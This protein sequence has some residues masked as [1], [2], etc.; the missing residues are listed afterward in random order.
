VGSAN[1]IQIAWVRET[2]P[3]TTP[4]SPRMR[5]VRATGESLDYTPDFVDSD[6]L[7][8]DRMQGAPI[9]VMQD[10]KGGLNS[11]L[12]F[13][14]DNSPASDIWRS[15]FWSTWVNTNSRDNDGVAD[16][17]IT[18]VATAG[19][20]VTCTTGTSFAANELVRFTGFG[21]T[22]NN[23]IFKCTTASATVPAFAGSG[24]TDEA[25]PPAAARMQVV[26]FI[27]AAGDINATASGISSTALN[28][29]TI[30]GLVAGKWLKIGGTG[31]G[32]RFVT[33]ALNAWV[34]ITAVAANAL[35]F[36]NLPSGW[37]TETGTGL[38]VKFWFGD[39]I[40]NGTTATSGTI[41]KG[42]MDQTV[43]TYIVERGLHVNTHNIDIKSQA[44]VTQT[45]DFLGMSGG[46]STVTLDAVADP[47]TT[48]LVMAANANVG[49]VAENGS[50]LT[51]PNWANMLSMKFS[52]NLRTLEAIDSTSPVGI[53]PGD[54]VAGGQLGLYFGDNSLLTKLYN[55]TATSLSARINKTSSSAPQALIWTY[56]TVYLRGGGNPQ[57]SG[58]NTDI[59]TTFD[60]Q[61][62]YNST[63]GCS[64]Q[65]DRLAY[66]ED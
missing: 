17:V 26:G 60:W 25:I 28:F 24:I 1:R 42:F 29:T 13:P 6:E 45:I 49:R 15:T 54:F 50:T 52:N 44:K 63:Y 7:R 4:V 39:Y 32:N 8:Q 47:V 40:R 21:I 51:S 65:L 19:T 20:V 41:E 53:Q 61:A 57:A 22:G 59:M 62:A 3:G 9:E 36:D 14:D 5:L 18:N 12:S 27:G 64:A 43:P 38:T 10:A 55:G 37:T 58:K 56:P 23:G 11:E 46:Q 66:Y 30:T 16:S 48:G 35:T 2:T 33:T 31:A 34:R